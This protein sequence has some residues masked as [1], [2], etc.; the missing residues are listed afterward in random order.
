MKKTISFGWKFIPGFLDS[1]VTNGLPASCQEVDIP[2]APVVEPINYF[3]EKNYQGLFSYEKSFDA[4]N[5]G[6]IVL[7]QFDGVMLKVHPYLNGVDLGEKI[8]GWVPVVYDIT[9]YVKPKNNRLLVVVDS[10]EDPKIPPFG[11]VVDYLTF[12]GIYRPVYLESK[13]A[14]YLSSLHVEGNQ[15]GHLHL[16]PTIK[17]DASGAT[18]TY[19][20]SY[21]GRVIK[22][23][24]ANDVTIPNPELWDLDHPC[25]YDLVATLS[26]NGESDSKSLRFGFRNARFTPHGFYLNGKKVKV[27]GLNR[28][29]NYPYVGPSLPASAQK[30]DAEI[31]KMKIGC[32][33]VRT[34]HYPDSEDFLTRCDELG[35][36]VIDEV[37][38]W[39]YIGKD[40]AWRDNFEYFIEAMVEKERNHPCLI[41]YGTRIDESPDDDELYGKALAYIHKTNPSRQCLGVRNFKT[42]HCLED[43]YC[44]NDFSC[45]SLNHGLDDPKSVKGAKGKPLMISEHNG[46]M[47]PT[48]QFDE[49]SKRLEHALRHLRVLD[50]AYRYSDLCGAIGWCAFDYNTHKDFGSGDHICYHGVS[51][52]FRNPKAAA[53]AYASQNSRL[54][55]M[56]IANPPTLGEYNECLNKP[57]YIFTNCDYVEL[58]KN[59]QFVDAFKPDKKDFPHLPHA[60]IVVDDFIGATLKE[61]GYSKSESAK[62]RQVLNYVGQVGI[63]HMQMSKVIG[64]LPTA[65]RHHLDA[66]KLSALYNKYMGA[67]DKAIIYTFRGFRDGKEVCLK[68][69]GP[70]TQFSYRFEVSNQHLQNADT[71]D[72]ARVAIK[73]VDEWGSQMHYTHNVLSFETHGP[74]AVIGPKQVA[75]EGGDIAVYIRSLATKTNVE[76]RLI[77]HTDQGDYPIDFTVE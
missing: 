51:D 39:Q 59:D 61:E 21:G 47:F 64:F 9:S 45:G 34:S 16:E 63:A 6:K 75:L 15:E 26:A 56:W 38:G 49:P 29:Q 62:L 42:S 36:M 8:S 35:L 73:L 71:Y 74:I 76:A 19:R 40:K 52:I 1:Y 54:P 27:V 55:V 44:Y 23:F 57:I 12:A 31:L 37:P 46:H 70:S 10:Q 50:D 3:D 4:P 14:T 32:N 13:P 48:K 77:V 18:L 30:E 2:H 24:D 68:K 58:Y 20:L 17:G 69:D 33:L 11:R 53:F 43:I 65:L 22:E 60:P 7:L 41:A 72:V 28:H 67:N 5:D 66:A 25:L